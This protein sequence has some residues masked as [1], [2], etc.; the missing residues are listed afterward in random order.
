MI[1][2]ERCS[3]QWQTMPMSYFNMRGKFGVQSFSTCIPLPCSVP[4]EGWGPQKSKIAVRRNQR[5]NLAI[6]SGY[7]HVITAI[8][9]IFMALLLGVRICLRICRL[10]NSNSGTCLKMLGF[11]FFVSSEFHMYL[12][13]FLCLST[14]CNRTHSHLILVYL[15][16]LDGVANGRRNLRD[17]WWQILRYLLSYY[18]ISWFIW[19]YS[20]SI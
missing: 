9:I 2:R 13:R 19:R 16:R 4:A 14:A 12:Y 18:K 20:Y 17:I 6:I 1:R 15:C 3:W 8:I 10:L 7:C 5:L 11:S